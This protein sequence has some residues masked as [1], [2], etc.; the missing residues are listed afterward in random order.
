[1]ADEAGKSLKEKMQAERADWKQRVVDEQSDVKGKVDRLHAFIQSGGYY[2]VHDDEK[3]LL[4]HQLNCM[5][6]YLNVL[7]ARIKLHKD[8]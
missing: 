1:M 4:Q 5:Q 3:G 7:N 2:N 6:E 8:I